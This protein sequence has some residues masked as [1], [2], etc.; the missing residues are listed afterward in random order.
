MF[1]P[2]F[3]GGYMYSEV[4]MDI[5]NKCNA[6]CYYCKTGQSNLTGQSHKISRYD[7]TVEDFDK[8][9][10]HLLENKIITENCLFRIYNWY[11]P[12]L[13]PNL[14]DIINYMH[15]H[16]L[17]L[18]MSTNASVLPDFSKIKTCE[19]FTGILFSMPGFS[20]HS[21]DKIH[22]FC[23][24]KIKDNIRTTMSEIRKRGFKGDAYINYHLYQFNIE[25]VYEAKKF[26]DEIGIRLHTMF[27]YY[28]GTQGFE[29]YI[30]ET[31]TPEIMKKS[32]QD[33][34]FYFV[35]DLMKEKEKYKKIFVEPP[36]ITLSEYCNVLPGRGSN[37]DDAIC[38]IY[39]LHSAQEVE[40]V[41]QKVDEKRNPDFEKVGYWA[42]SYKLSMNHLFGID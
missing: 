37:D 36:S 25:E 13:N 32:S 33:L 40:E 18:D 22:G 38:S 27:A 6:R 5:V 8:L 7:M 3:Y 24:E 12:T 26:A 41:Y 23:F 14:P 21:Y 31:M 42:M 16:G 29:E 1:L 34:F 2:F 20:Q 39:D 15:D 17:R 9:V 30:K 35:D 4:Y 19:H 11:E 10:K 28:N